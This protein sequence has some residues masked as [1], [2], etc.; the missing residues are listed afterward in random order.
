MATKYPPNLL[1]S[2]YA[3]S[4]DKTIPPSTADATG[5]RF[6][7]KY[8]WQAI[9]S[10]VIGQ[11]GIPPYR[12]DFNGAFYQL[13]TFA[14]WYQQGGLMTYDASLT[15]EVGN[16][17]L[18]NGTKYRCIK[19][20]KGHQPPNATYWKN[21]DTPSNMVLSVNNIL[22]DAPGN[23]ALDVGDF[24][25]V[26]TASVLGGIK[27]GSNL[28]ITSAGV[29]SSSPVVTQTASNANQELPLLAKNTTGTA[30]VTDTSRFKSNVT[31]NP[32]LGRITA[33]TFRGNLSGDAGSSTATTQRTGDSSNRIATTAFV[34]NVL[35]SFLQV[36]ESGEK[37]VRFDNGFQIVWNSFSRNDGK[38]GTW[39]FPVAFSNSSYA[40]VIGNVI[41]SG[42]KNNYSIDEKKPTYLKYDLAEENNI[43]IVCIGWWKGYTDS[44]SGG[45]GGSSAAPL[46]VSG[47][48]TYSTNDHSTDETRISVRWTGGTAPYTLTLNNQQVY[49]GTAKTY[50]A[51]VDE[52][53]FIAV[54]TDSAG[55]RADTIIGTAG[56]GSGEDY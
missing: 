27:V 33:T 7:Q 10:K 45:S 4:G 29:L 49:S 21:V 12:E 18:S 5:G 54:V 43:D 26:A 50:S 24:L 40:A 34:K 55:Q 36:S 39:T 15:Y 16:E 28:S 44:S 41:G 30:T 51:V 37:F 25:P 11:G 6:S 1:A 52:S 8:G 19:A 23:V 38:T 31:L 56:S 53:Y 48:L 13:S 47:S 14:L 42:D 22:P 32:S 2:A 35:Q 46:S 3:A 17:I 20:G 9:N